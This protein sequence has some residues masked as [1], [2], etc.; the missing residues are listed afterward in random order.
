MK[1]ITV[2]LLF[3]L[4]IV[5]TVLSYGLAMAKKPYYSE[6]SRTND[7]PS[8]VKWDTTLG[9]YVAHEIEVDPDTGKMTDT[10]IKSKA[11][12]DLPDGYLDDTSKWIEEHK[13]TKS[14]VEKSLISYITASQTNTTTNLKSYYDP[15][16]DKSFSIMTSLDVNDLPEIIYLIESNDMN[17]GILMYTAEYITGTYNGLIGVDDT[18]RSIW[19]SNIKEKIKKAKSLQI[20]EPN[21]I[22]DDELLSLGIF[23]IPTLIG[24]FK[25]DKTYTVSFLPDLV[26]KGFKEFV[27]EKSQKDQLFWDKWLENHKN[28]FDSVYDIVD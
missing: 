18:N 1:K 12:T 21:E 4:I 9:C 13:N 15:R 10:S 17:A 14:K 8:D 5:V 23:S 16:D 22:S 25:K 19:I 3:V 7:V 24:E 2:K 27:D 28:S 6:P 20:S 11:S 26:Q